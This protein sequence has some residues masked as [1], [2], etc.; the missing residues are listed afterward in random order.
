MNLTYITKAAFIDSI[1]TIIADHPAGRL[2]TEHVDWS[3]TPSR[4]TL[5]VGNDGLTEPSYAR[6]LSQCDGICCSAVH[7]KT[8]SRCKHC[9]FLHPS[10][11]CTFK[12]SG[13]HY[14]GQQGH[15]ENNGRIKQK[16]AYKQNSSKSFK[17]KNVKPV[18]EPEPEHEEHQR[19]A[20]NV[21]DK[22]TLLKVSCNCLKSVKPEMFNF[23]LNDKSIPLEID[24]GSCVSLLGEN[25]IKVLNVKMTPSS[26]EL[27]AY[28]GHQIKR[29]NEQSR[30][31]DEALKVNSVNDMDVSDNPKQ[32]LDS[33]KVSDNLP[34]KGVEAKIYV[35]KDATPKFIKARLVPLTHKEL[36]DIAIQEL[37][38]N[39]VI[40]PVAY[41]DWALPIVPVLKDSGKMR[42]CADF[43]HLNGQINIEKCPLPKLDEMLATVGDNK[44]FCKLDLCNAYLQI[45]VSE[46]QKY[47]VI[48]TEK[49]LPFG[50]ASAP[51]I[52]QRYIPQLLG[53]IDGLIV[54]LYD[55]LICAKSREDP[56]N[57]VKLVLNKLAKANV[58]L[59]LEKC[60]FNKT[61]IDFLS[62]VISGEGL[63]PSPPNKV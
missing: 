8:V 9:G 40:E 31:K 58:M 7:S 33:Y 48:S 34:I 49:G 20:Y 50:V 21:A 62:Y 23:V 13:C 60:E 42:I 54:Y 37:V 3:V 15:L 10:S 4:T 43:K 14:C 11:A 57:K 61:V 59:N 2:R 38:E 1:Y 27:T 55:I 5:T 63:S 51:G 26:K 52:F 45:K 46:D 56:S 25:W 53:D 19:S 16:D 30:H 28:G 44:V 32:L 47:L 17:N 22:N 36:V 12:D 24:S 18:S 29:S 41:S 6:D 35:K 39:E